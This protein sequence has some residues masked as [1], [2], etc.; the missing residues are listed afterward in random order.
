MRNLGPKSEAWLAEIDIHTLDDL[1]AIGAVEAYARLRFRFGDIITRNMLH[2]MAAALA[3][4]DWR[5]LSV[6]RKAELEEQANERLAHF[7]VTEN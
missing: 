2:A 1:R 5:Q 4:I 3:D 6:Q 7:D